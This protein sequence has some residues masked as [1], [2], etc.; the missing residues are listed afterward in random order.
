MTIEKDQILFAKTHPNAIIPTKRYEDGC[1]D[2]HACVKDE[3]DEIV[4]EPHEYE[5]VG[6]GIASAFSPKYRFD[7]SRERGSTGFGLKPNSG[8]VDSGYRG[9]WFIK[10]HN[11]TNKKIIIS[12]RYKEV[13]ELE[14]RIEYPITKA[15]CQAALEIVPDVDAKEVSYELLKSIPS[16]RG[17]GKEGSSGK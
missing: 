13:K 5:K 16:E 15:V 17:F 7:L 1:Y 3:T 2:I 6:T 12:S 4:I 10:L 11:I 14:D 9:E 8:Q